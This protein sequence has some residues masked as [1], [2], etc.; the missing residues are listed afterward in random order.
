MY[1]YK[2]INNNDFR[3]S[4]QRWFR[5]TILS[6]LY[7]L[8]LIVDIVMFLLVSI[9]L[10]NNTKIM[11]SQY[12][13]MFIF[14]IILQVVIL[15]IYYKKEVRMLLDNMTNGEM[16]ISFDETGID[17]SSENII[18]HIKWSGVKEINADKENLLLYYKVNGINNN[19]FLF[20]HFDSSR[21]EI[22]GEIEK[23]TKVKR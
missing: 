16:T 7:K 6:R 3:L 14:A 22:I 4:Y 5:N 10:R 15:Q 8:I 23:Y 13:I 11:I 12:L 2:F 21:E 17:I 18:R 20:K 19:I 1:T 9:S